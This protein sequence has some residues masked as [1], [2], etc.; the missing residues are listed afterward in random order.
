MTRRL[1]TPQLVSALAIATGMIAS[2][3]NAAPK[4]FLGNHVVAFG[5]VG[6]SAELRGPRLQPFARSKVSLQPYLFGDAAWVWNKNDGIG[7]EHLKSAGGGVRAE[8]G[9]RFRLDSALAVP[10]EKAGILNRKGDIRLLVTL[11]SR[12]LP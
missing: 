6:V 5:D 9:D 12:I 2:Q 4:G 11:T 3:T 8:L 7:A 1:S 10:L